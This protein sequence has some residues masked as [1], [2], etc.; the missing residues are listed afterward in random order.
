MS[1]TAHATAAR[2]RLLG[3]FGLPDAP[4]APDPDCTRPALRRLLAA[5]LATG[6]LGDLTLRDPG[7]GL[8]L[9]LLLWAAAAATALAIRDRLGALPR[10]AAL[11]LATSAA[12][13]LAIAVRAEPLLTLGN[14]AASAALIVWAAASAAPDSPLS[15]LRTRLRALR[16]ALLHAA[17]VV[18]FGPFTRLWPDVAGAV[19]L[20]A[21]HRYA[22]GLLL[23]A[24]VVAVIAGLP[25]FA[26]LAAGDPVFAALA[27]D[28]GGL[29]LPLRELAGHAVGTLALA[30]PLAAFL[31]A[32]RRPWGDAD[33]ARPAP[34]R[35]PLTA[36]DVRAALGTVNVL[37]AVFV[38]VQARALFGGRDYVMATTGLTFA[39]YARSGFFTLATLGFATLGLLLAIEPRLDPD[40]PAARATFRR[41]ASALM[42]LVGVVLA[43][44]VTRMALY[45]ATWGLTLDRLYTLGGM[46]WLGCT[47]ALYRVTVLGRAP[48]RFAGGAVVAGLGLLGAMNALDPAALAV[49]VNLARAT[50]EAPFDALWASGLGADAAPALVEALTDPAYDARIVN[51]PNVLGFAT[52]R[53]ALAGALL[54]G[55][56]P[57]RDEAGFGTSLA[58]WRARQAVAVAAPALTSMRCPTPRSVARPAVPATSATAPPAVT[59]PAAPAPAAPAPQ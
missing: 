58:S 44:A 18:V 53:C 1:S 56:G 25:A 52:G 43:S 32:T 11:L 50:A 24:A 22:G 5:A 10:E 13:A 26:L 12:F 2:A 6:V 16:A 21:R 39:E 38:G 35:L 7:V 57:Q 42:L 36:L 49:R 20:P 45:V 46:A 15:L 59:S 54:S 14:L 47:F 55:W 37:L 9:T 34:V 28:L 31:G 8:N 19:A 48:H 3:A 33:A 51:A 30:L 27:D 17:A 29:P 23:R 4:L 41:H 40:A